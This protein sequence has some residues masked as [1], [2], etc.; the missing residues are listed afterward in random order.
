VVGAPMLRLHE[1]A[2]WLVLV[3]RQPIHRAVQAAGEKVASLLDFR[4]FTERNRPVHTSVS[5]GAGQF[6]SD[7]TRLGGMLRVL[8]GTTIPGLGEALVRAARRFVPGVAINAVGGTN[9]AQLEGL[10]GLIL[11]RRE[12]DAEDRLTLS[13]DQ[14][15]D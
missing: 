2:H 8:L 3:S 14:H 7:L 4:T 1:G 15:Q 6:Q 5:V 10:L 11:T 13:V 9:A 12:I